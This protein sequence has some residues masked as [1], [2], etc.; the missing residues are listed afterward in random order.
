MR[1]RIVDLFCKAGG[2]TRGYQL[3][4]FHV[5]GVDI[6]PQPNYCGDEFI[7]A[8]ALTVSLDGFDAAHASPPCQDDL[9]GLKEVNRLLSREYDHPNLL[10]PTRAR[11]QASGLLYVIEQPEQGAKL[12]NPIRLC[13]SS[14]GLPLRRHRQF[15]SDVLLMGRECEHDRHRE[16]KYWTSWR[17]N[18]EHRLATTVQVYGNAGDRK[19]WGPALGIDWMTT[20]ELTQAIPPAYTQHIGWQLMVELRARRHAL[21]LSAGAA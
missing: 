7:Q 15:E 14:F 20:E 11:L 19:T 5:T 4:G 18:G 8:D 17:P 1:P 3:A 6:E 10:I 13:G 12:L 2:A 21:K 9:K 16:K